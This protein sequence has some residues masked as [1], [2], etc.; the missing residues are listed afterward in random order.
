MRDTA[1]THLVLA[2]FGTSLALVFLLY[3]VLI[4]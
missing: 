1:L 4:R 3:I 2:S